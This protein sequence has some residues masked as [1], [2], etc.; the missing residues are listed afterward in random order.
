MLTIKTL[1]TC[2]SEESTIGKTIAQIDSLIL[3][4]A[5]RGGTQVCVIPRENTSKIKK[6][7]Q[8]VGFTVTS[9]PISPLLLTISW[10][11]S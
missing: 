10:Q 6:H 7:Y 4:N 5:Y 1:I 3:S 11:I 2:L 9:D 8:N